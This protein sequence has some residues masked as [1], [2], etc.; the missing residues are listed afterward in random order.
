MSKYKSPG[1][2]VALGLRLYRRGV[3]VFVYLSILFGFLYSPTLFRSFSQQKTLNVYAFTET[4][5]PDAIE[6][7]E[8]QF[9]VKV[10][11]T[12]AELDEEIG[13]KFS[14]N[15]GDGYDVVNVSDFMVKQL[16]GGGYLQ[17][18]DKS[19]VPSIQNIN[20]RLMHQV[21][22]FNNDYSIP[23]KWFMYGLIYDKTFFSQKP[24]EMSL[25]FVFTDP[26]VLFA[27]GLV[28]APYRSCM[29]DSP[30]DA[31]FLSMRYLY[32][33]HDAF[34]E[35]DFAAIT[36]ALLKQKNSIECYTL[37]SVEYFLL[38][39]LVP[40]ALTSSNF[41]RKIWEMSDK[42][43]FAIPKEGGIL[44]I[45]NLVV[46]KTSAKGTLAHQFINFMLS[47]EI[48]R[49]NSEEYGWTSANL[50]VQQAIDTGFEQ[51]SH[52]LPDEKIFTR[53]H[54]PL[55]TPYARKHADNAWLRVGF[56]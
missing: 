46:P 51:G 6:L 44:V 29:I 24:D 20:P 10:N 35:K 7:F 15:G 47:D 38:S 48:A 49:V 18:L 50:G 11:M 31:Y 17:R 5:S 4:F 30:M 12:Y 45:E 2:H 22:D 52:L 37:Y 19:A 33:R 34:F 14:I 13:A 25:A 32:S 16:I 40:I 21:F 43:E 9:G 54:I 41:V 55:F 42:Y 26:K 53:L 56:A 36:A 28:K 39:G 3:I 1:S 23:H 27:Q 8:K